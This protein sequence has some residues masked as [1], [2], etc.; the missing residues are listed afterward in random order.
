MSIKDRIDAAAAALNELIAEAEADGY[1]ACVSVG[2]STKT[3]VRSVA[4]SLM[5]ERN[6]LEDGE[7]LSGGAG[8]AQEGR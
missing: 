8:R 6:Y 2:W 4:V 7:A 5:K 1:T 3:R